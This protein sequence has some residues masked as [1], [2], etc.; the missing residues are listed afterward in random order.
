MVSATGN[1]LQHRRLSNP[2]THK[3]AIVE[4][5]EDTQPTNKVAELLRYHHQ[6]G[7]ISFRKLQLMAKMV[8]LPRRL[9]NLPS[10]GMFGMSIHQSNQKSMVIPNGKEQRGTKQTYEAR[11][12][13]LGRSASITDPGTRCPNK[14]ESSPPRGTNT[15][16]YTWTKSQS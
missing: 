9:Q 11:P 15:P 4:E 2:L 6:F 13:G 1:V 14:R 8:V 3:P 12:P 5:E 7:H 16:Q 10:T